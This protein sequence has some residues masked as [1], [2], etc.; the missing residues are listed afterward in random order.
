MNLFDIIV[1]GIGITSTL[2][3]L[4]KGFI[5]LTLGLISFLLSLLATFFLFPIMREAAV[6]HITNE[7]AADIASGIVSYL[8][9]MFF[10]AF[11]CG[12][13]AKSL[14]V[15]S[16]GMVDRLLGLGAGAARGL[17]I[18]SIIFGI[19]AIISSEAYVSARTAKD[20]AA[21]IDPP[22]Y[23]KWLTG[24]ISYDVIHNSASILG[25]LIPSSQLEK[26]KLPARTMPEIPASVIHDAAELGARR[27]MQRHQDQEREKGKSNGT[28]ESE[29][30]A[31]LGE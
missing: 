8:I 17:I 6:E 9:S 23:P 21:K 22:K 28:L 27:L 10:C 26:I 30:E 16:G 25:S 3:G 12:Q 31:M 7:L 11:L 14:E 15:I 4:H 1:L 24:A 13:I 29:I 18:C 5:K 19:I 2:L 20:M